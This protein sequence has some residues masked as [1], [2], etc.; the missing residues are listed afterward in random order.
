MQGQVFPILLKTKTIKS[1]IIN[2]KD[3]V[4]LHISK[5]TSN[6]SV[7]D[8]LPKTAENVLTVCMKMLISACYPVCAKSH[9]LFYLLPF[10]EQQ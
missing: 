10:I 2:R 6:R 4:F 7:Y 1:Q 8:L 9:A 5:N 3:Q